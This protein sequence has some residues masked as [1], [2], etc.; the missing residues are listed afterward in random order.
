MNW[1]GF[2]SGLS[3]G[4]FTGVKM[5]NTLKDL[6]KERELQQIREKGLAEAGQMRTNKINSMIEDTGDQPVQAAKVESPEPMKAFDLPPV[7]ATTPAAQ[8]TATP[9][10]AAP[11][12]P[13]T[14]A[15]TTPATVTPEPV[16]PAPVKEVQNTVI[17]PAQGMPGRYK[18]GDKT[19]QTR[20]EALSYAEKQAP[21]LQDI[22]LKT[23]SPRMQEYYLGQ[24]DIEKAEAWRKYADSRENQKNMDT[25]A[26]AYRAASTGNFEKAA[27]HVFDLYKAYDDGITPLSKEVVKDKQGNIQ[28]FNVK[29]RGADGKEFTQLI[30]PRELTE[31]GLSALS[32][33]AMFEMQFKRQMERD[34]ITGE[35]AKEDR[36][37]KRDVQMEGIKTGNEIEKITIQEQLKAAN[38]TGTER[39]KIEAK[40]SALKSAG[41]SEQFINEAMPSIIGLGEYKRSTSPEEAR[42]LAYSDR[43][44]NDPTFSRKSPE[45]REK[46]LDEDMK[47]VY[48]GVKPMAAPRTP[49]AAGLPQT[50]TPQSGAPPSKGTPVWDSKTNSVIYR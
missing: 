11:A 40:I 29:L 25:W 18:V 14:S 48:S 45:D 6:G 4:F 41:Y 33:P 2:A 5:G 39:K 19:F 16:A 37:F 21:S 22:Q 10:S 46:I 27:D 3:T 47:L 24:G 17:P 12:T 9:S 36:K 1:G 26:K 30:T 35:I 7:G 38:I 31:L 34:K 42:R 44:K 20:E 23:L 13:S 49:A 28:G 43:M 15:E 8:S 50:G 32:P